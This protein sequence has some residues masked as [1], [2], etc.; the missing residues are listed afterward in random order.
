M[1]ARNIPLAEVPAFGDLLGEPR[2]L[3][4][5]SPEER[6]ARVAF[7][8]RR[9]DAT[10][11]RGAA[12]DLILSGEARYARMEGEAKPRQILLVMEDKAGQTTLQLED[13]NELG[14]FVDLERIDDAYRHAREARIAIEVATR[15]GRV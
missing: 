7:F 4:T 3:Q 6:A 13:A 11:R 9:I 8:G 12:R 10:L 5:L 14:V 2:K 15:A 1:E